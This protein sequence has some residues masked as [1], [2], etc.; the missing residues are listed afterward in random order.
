MNIKTIKVGGQTIRVAVRPG[1]TG[2]PLVLCNGI[3]A[4]LELWL[5]LIA[6]I[7]PTIEVIAFDVPGVGG[8]PGTILP[9]RFA[10]LANTLNQLLDRMGYGQVDVLGLSWGG[11]LAQQ[12]AHDYPTR[13][14]RLIL[15]ATSTGWDS[16]LPNYKVLMMMSSPRRYTDVEYAA[17]IIPNI[18]GGRFRRDPELVLKHAQKMVADRAAVKGG[19]T[20]LGYTYQMTALYWHST[21]SM[22]RNI[23]QPT[24]LLA[25]RDDPIIPLCN[26]EKMASKIPD[27]LLQVFDDG[28]LFLLTDLKNV[29]PYITVFLKEQRD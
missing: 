21:T 22:L 6:V 25:G 28:H 23:K 5:P 14:R 1:T 9:Y 16:T 19:G 8:S 3:G 20:D 2:T 10:C 24:L 29:I 15:A 26:M 4:S 11:F 13:C 27:S 18:Y 17:K 7:D 12:F